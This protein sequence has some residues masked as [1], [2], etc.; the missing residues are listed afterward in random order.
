[1]PYK[2]QEQR[3]QYQLTW[4]W[5]RRMSWILANG[6]CKQCGSGEGLCVVY[7]NPADKTVRVT[8]IWSLSDERRTEL[9]AKC[10]VLCKPCAQSKRHEERQPGHGTTGRYTQGCRCTDCTTA[11]RDAVRRWRKGKHASD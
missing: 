2:A 4:I 5:R 10:I 11:H 6:P 8:S 1:M 3:R 7:K 9:L